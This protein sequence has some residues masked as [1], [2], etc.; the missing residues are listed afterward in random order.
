MLFDLFIFF[1]TWTCGFTPTQ[2]VSWLLEWYVYTLL[3]ISTHRQTCKVQWGSLSHA[4]YLPSSYSLS[5]LYSEHDNTR[6]VCNKQW[7]VQIWTFYWCSDNVDL[8]QT[9]MRLH[10][11]VVWL[12]YLSFLTFVVNLWIH[13]YSVGKLTI[14]MVHVQIVIHFDS[15]ADMQGLVR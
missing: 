9:V 11:H 4:S 13:S 8:H 2:M 14:R 12:V 15:E 1:S 5:L 10:N 7:Y 3:Y 6:L